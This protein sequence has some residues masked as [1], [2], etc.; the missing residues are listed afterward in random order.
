MSR[1]RLGFDQVN[2]RLDETQ[3]YDEFAKQEKDGAGFVSSER[4][5]EEHNQKL[6]VSKYKIQE[7]L[8]Q[9][10]LRLLSSPLF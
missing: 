8:L 7:L 10:I 1:L 4:V 3:Q 2:Q 5:D 9:D 6:E